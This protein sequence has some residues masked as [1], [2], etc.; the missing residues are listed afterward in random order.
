MIS[1]LQRCYIAV[2]TKRIAIIFHE[3]EPKSSLPRFAV[4][5]LAASW[6]EQN[7]QVLPVFGIR[8][9]VPADL[10][11]LHVDLTTV[12]QEY[13]D[14]ASRYPV[15]LNGRIKD[16]RKSSFS[17]HRVSRGDGYSGK[18]IVKSEL[19]YAGQPER[20]LL[21][22]PLSR[23]ALRI[24]SRFPA[25]TPAEATGP[26]FRKPGDYRIFDS[27][28]SV[29]EAWFERSDLLI[30]RFL[31]EIED[32]LYC[33]RSHHFM[34]DRGSC[35]I[36]RSRH[37]IV[38][39]ATSIS[40]EEVAPDPEIVERTRQMGF[41]FGKF[42]YVLHEGKAVLLDTNKTPGAG[43]AAAFFVMCREWAKG[44]WQYF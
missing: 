16:I 10:A 25:L 11:L 3:N 15:V 32:G 29:P 21:G 6:R 36:R 9:F 17:Q 35:I 41:D 38:N 31:P 22:T 14:F 4:W 7:I 33:L 37:P 39:A 2:M 43:K 24:S 19:N 23:M 28:S 1:R 5:H 8:K 12:P 34:G 44:I 27:S 26:D 20:K 30:E 13:L 18:V 40:R 42:D